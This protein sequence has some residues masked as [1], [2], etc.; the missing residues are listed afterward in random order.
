MNFETYFGMDVLKMCNKNNSISIL[1]NL[2]LQN[3]SF[4][5]KRSSNR[6]K[7]ATQDIL[8]LACS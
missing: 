1:C 3:Q 4:Y 5:A 8:F 6:N 2:T 7:T